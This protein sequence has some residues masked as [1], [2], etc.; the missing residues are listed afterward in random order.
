MVFSQKTEKERGFPKSVFLGKAS[1]FI[2]FQ[3]NSLI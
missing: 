1:F 3:I 2:Y